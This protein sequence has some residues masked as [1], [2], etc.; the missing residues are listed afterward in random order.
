MTRCHFVA[1]MKYGSIGQNQTFRFYELSIRSDQLQLVHGSSPTCPTTHETLQRC[2]PQPLGPWLSA[3]PGGCQLQFD[4]R[5][6]RNADLLT[7]AC[8]YFSFAE[9][10]SSLS[11]F[12]HTQCP[13]P[14]TFC[15]SWITP[16]FLETSH[17]QL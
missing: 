6:S 15:Q 2:Q 12:L 7:K 8:T 13:D 10:E 16:L 9:K 1:T 4:R 17:I 14:T 11:V 3:K 5:L